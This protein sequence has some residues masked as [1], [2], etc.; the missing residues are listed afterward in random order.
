MSSGSHLQTG[1]SKWANQ[2]SRL[3]KELFL[4]EKATSDLSLSPSQQ[5]LV[6]LL[7]LQLHQ[8]E[9]TRLCS[10]EDSLDKTRAVATLSSLSFLLLALSSLPFSKGKKF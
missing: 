7:S 3:S 5:G 4:E 10:S 8:A 2:D 6:S 1:N 9:H